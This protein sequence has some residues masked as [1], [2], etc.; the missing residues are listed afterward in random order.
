MA[1][2]PA[3]ESVYI[4]A[5]ACCL[6]NVAPRDIL[7]ITAALASALPGVQAAVAKLDIGVLNALSP[8]VLA[9][10]V[11]ELEIDPFEALRQIRFV[12][13]DCSIVVF[14]NSAKPTFARDCH[15]AG[16]NCLLSKLSNHAQLVAGIRHAMRSGCFTD[17]RFSQIA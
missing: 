5:R 9:I 13:P 10:D 16:A 12:I 4:M 2:N 3:S 17:P 14:T 8:D 7:R 11:D 6:V 15:N 1:K